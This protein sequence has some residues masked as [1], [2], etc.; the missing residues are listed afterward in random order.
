MSGLTAAL[1]A[2]ITTTGV[3]A[4]IAARSWPSPGPGRRRTPRAAERL[5]D[6]LDPTMTIREEASTQ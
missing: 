5:A 4:V 2:A 6:R 1:A 3:G